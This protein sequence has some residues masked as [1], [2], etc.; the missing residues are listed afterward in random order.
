[1]AVHTASEVE[2]LHLHCCIAIFTSL[3]SRCTGVTAAP[4]FLSRKFNSP[5]FLGKLLVF[6]MGLIAYT[7]ESTVSL[8]VTTSIV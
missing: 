7:L 5:T 2:L 6:K 3:H 4:G 8:I 1:M